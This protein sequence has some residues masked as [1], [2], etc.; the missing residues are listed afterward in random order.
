VSKMNCGSVPYCMITPHT[1]KTG[2]LFPYSLT[3]QE[4]HCDKNKTGCSGFRL[5]AG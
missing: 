4:L 5:S 2:C 1:S 3:I